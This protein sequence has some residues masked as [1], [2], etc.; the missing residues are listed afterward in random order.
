MVFIVGKPLVLGLVGL[1]HLW[2]EAHLE[3]RTT[4]NTE[5]PG[6]FTNVTRKTAIVFYA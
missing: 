5:Y 4:R 2:T 1:I 6:N 3:H